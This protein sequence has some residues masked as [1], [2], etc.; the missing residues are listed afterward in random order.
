M[1]MK[2][3]RKVLAPVLLGTAFLRPTTVLA[4]DEQAAHLLSDI[5]GKLLL[6]VDHLLDFWIVG[7]ALTEPNGVQL[8]AAIATIVQ[9]LTVF[10]AQISTFL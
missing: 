4:Q 5:T 3:V 10:V 7:Y 1:V 2:P 6:L 8:T 9:N